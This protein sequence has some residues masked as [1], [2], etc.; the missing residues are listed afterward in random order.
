MPSTRGDFLIYG[1]TGYTGNLISELA[2]KRGLSPVL[3]GRNPE[4][5]REL[6]ARL[7]LPYQVASLDDTESLER[8][9]DEVQL[10][11]NLAGPFAYT[12]DVLSQLCIQRRKHY[13]DVTGELTV[14][15]GLH[16]KHAAALRNGVMLLPGAG[17]AIV[18]SDCLAAML[19]R[20]H[21][22]ATA[23]RIGVSRP[24]FV[25]RSSARTMF[26]QFKGGPLVRRDG[27][28]QSLPLSDFRTAFDFGQGESEC[29][30]VN[31]P[32]VFTAGLY[33]NFDSVS[34]FAESN[35]IE[36]EMY[37]MMS[38]SMQMFGA[39][40]WQ[41]MLSFQADYLPERPSPSDE[42]CD[43][44]FVAEA[45]DSERREVGLLRLRTPQGYA[46]SA[47][48]ACRVIERVLAGASSPGFQTPSNVFGR[49]LVLSAN[50]VQFES[51]RAH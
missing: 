38:L 43:R 36:G 8:A 46:F 13:I 16:Q 34:T 12:A 18:P 29:V 40:L 37:R 21:P 35:L 24:D 32:D 30:A 3:C 7:E 33:C 4:R 26:E 20:D 42:L 25:S 50:G 28:L 44:V 45:L 27:V 15:Q 5:V 19:R 39:N 9:M 2:K 49:E 22:N 41:P 10:V 11:L 23:L 14:F 31:W 6:A 48:I 1:A 17:F 51:L 47:D